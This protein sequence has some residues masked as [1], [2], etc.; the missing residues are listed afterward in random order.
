MFS[1]AIPPSKPSLLQVAH[2]PECA[3]KIENING[4]EQP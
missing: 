4:N 1:T 2:R 3:E